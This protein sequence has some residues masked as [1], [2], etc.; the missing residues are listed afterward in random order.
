MNVPMNTT[1]SG[2]KPHAIAS[3]GQGT[4][5]LGWAWQGRA[6]VGFVGQHSTTRVSICSP[7]HWGMSGY[8]LTQI[9]MG[10]L[11]AV[12][13]MCSLGRE[14]SPTPTLSHPPGP[15]CT[16]RAPVRTQFSPFHFHPPAI[17]T[18]HAPTHP[19]SLY[20]TQ[21]GGTPPRNECLEPKIPTAKPAPL[22][23]LF[24]RRCLGPG[25]SSS[26]MLLLSFFFL[27]S[28]H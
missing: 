22:L 2:D 13:G 11:G 7:L 15:T 25:L 1:C 17:L 20:H 28:S 14:A 6:D 24:G 21:P 23:Y 27:L 5:V 19:H 10:L 16:Q 9:H 12:K 3:L 4:G 26:N 8:A 18:Y